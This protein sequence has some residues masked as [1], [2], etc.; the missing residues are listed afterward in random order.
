M[1]LCL[2][3]LVIDVLFA[4]GKGALP[5]TTC[6]R[7]FEK[8][9]CFVDNTRQGGAL[10]TLPDLLVNDRDPKSDAYDGHRLDWNKWPESIHSLACRCAN[11]TR[12]KGW[13]VFGLQFYGECWSGENGETTFNKYG[14]ANPKKCIQELVDPLP[15]CNKSKD[16]ECVGV[17]STNYI[18]KLKELK[19]Q[20]VNGGFSSWSQWT[21]CSK[22]CGGGTKSRER[23][24]TNP[25]PSGNGQ[26]CMG[27]AEEVEKCNEDQ[28]PD[29]CKRSLDVGLLID[30]ST[31]VGA[32]NFKKTLGFLS[33]L[34]GHLS[35]S[36]QGTHV[37]VMVFESQA[38]LHFNL[39]KSEYHSLSKLQSAIRALTYPGKGIRT[40]LALQMAAS[41]IFDSS[42]GDR[43]D[44][45]NLLVVLT[46]G[47]T[48]SGST[49]YKDVITLLQKKGVRTVA[50]GVG[51]KIDNKELLQIAAGN[52]KYVTHVNGFD[53]LRK[54][55]AKIVL[56]SCQGAGDVDGAW[57]DWMIWTQ[58]SKSC[59]GGVKARRRSCSN[60]PPNRNGQSC[61]GL[62]QET[63]ACSENPCPKPCTKALDVGIILDGSGSVR[64]SNFEKAKEF[65]RDLIEHFSVSPKGTHF[66]VIIYSTSPKLQLDFANAA[67]HRIVEL[68]KRVMSIKYPGGLTRTDKALEM[69]AQKLFTVAGGDRKDKPNVLLVFT[70]GKTNRGSKPYPVVLRPL[71]ARG[72]RTVAVGIGRGINQRELLQIAMSNNHYVV[73]VQNF[74]SLKGKLQMILDE[75]CQDA[76]PPSPNPECREGV[77]GMENRNIP[78]KAITASSQWDANHGPDRAR[79]NMVRSGHKRGA[80]SAKY[81]DIGQF[82]QVDI[83]KVVKI[84]KVLTQGRSDSDQWVKTYW[85]SYSLNGGYYQAYGE[86][87]PVTLTGNVDRNTVKV[88]ILDEPIY[89]RFIRVHP[90]TFHRHI[91]LRLELYGC[92]TGFVPPSPPLCMNALGMQSGKIRPADIQASSQYDHNHRPDNGRLHFQ[93]APPRT[94]AWSS[95]TNNLNQWFQVKFER[96]A[97]VRRVGCQGRMDADQWVKKY[98]LAYSFDGKNWK[99]YGFNGKV[100]EF[101]GN[102]DRYSV[103]TET[104]DPPIIARYVRVK[105]RAW[106]RHISLRLEF[107]GCTEDGDICNVK[108]PCKNGA[109]CINLVGGYSCK[110]PDG[111]KGKN[112]DQDI[113]ECLSSPCKNG[114]RCT[115]TAGGYTCKCIGGWFT[116]KNCD[117]APPECIVNTKLSEGNRASGNLR[118]NFLKCD[119]R[120]LATVGKW[121][122]FVGDAGT[123]IP[124][125]CVPTQR[126]GTHAPGWMQGEHP[127]KEDGVVNRK[128]CFHWSRNCCRWSVLIKVRNCSGYF[129][130][131]LEKPPVCYLRYCGDKGHNVCEP[132]NPCRNGG[133]CKPQGSGYYC[134]CRPGYQG[135]NCDKDINECAVN[136]PCRNGGTCINAVGRYR[137]R[138]S[139]KFTGR[140]CEKDVNECN[141]HKPCKNG[142]TCV[143]NVGGYSCRCPANYKGRH[144]DKDVNECLPI[145]PCKN[146]GVCKNTRG[147]YQCT[148]VGR[149]FTGKLCDQD[150]NECLPTN[151]CKNGGVCKNIKGSYQCTCNGRFYGGKNCD[152]APV[153]CSSYTTLNTADRASKPSNNIFKCDRNDLSAVPKWYRFS[154]AAGTKMPTSSV[155]INHCGTRAPGWMNGQH[156]S[157][158]DGPVS[159]KVCFHWS[160]NVCRWSIQITVRSCGSFFVYKLPRT[161]YCSLRYCG[162][163]GYN[164]CMVKNPCQN[165]GTCQPDGNGYKCKC[166]PGFTGN[167]CEQDVNECLPINPCKNGGVCKNTKGSYQCTCNGRFYGGKNCDQAPV[168]CSSYT[169]LNTADRAS[170]PSN[171]IFKCD[172]N[173]LSSVPKWYRFSGAAGTKMP[174]SSVPINHCGTRAPGWMNGQHPSKNDGPVS[175]KVCFHW[176]NNVCRWSIQ[177]TVRSC[178]SF[179]VY[180][181]P[182]TNYCSLR[183][184]GDNGYNKCMVKNP[185]QNSGTCQPDGNGYKCK[186]SPGFTGNNCE[187]DVNECLPINPCKNGGVCK[188]TKG[189][190]QCTCNGRFYGG[191]NCDQ[192]PV[193]C[194]S[195]TTL[196]TADR[197]SKP[198]NNIFKCDRNDLSAVPK[199]YRFSGAAGTKMPTSSV[200]INHCGTRAPG[201]MNGQHPSKNDGPVS[202]KVCFHWSNN[203][204]RWS[205]QI[206]VRSCGSFFVYKL[207]RTNYCSLRYCGDNGY[208][209]CMVKNPCQNS[210][211]CQPDGNGYKCKCSP[212]F[213]GNNCEQ[214]VNEC[215]PINPCKN[216]GVCKNT[217]G[218]YQC[219]CV[220]R[221]Y[222]GKNC[223]RAPVECSS[224]TT[225]NTADRASKPSNNIFKCDRNDL[226]SVPKW[227][228]FSGAAGTKM[229]TSSVPINHCGTRAPGWMNGQHPSKNDGPVSRKVCFHWS[230]NVCRWSIQITVRSCGSFFVYKLPRTNYCSLRYCGDNGHNVDECATVKPCKNGGQCRN[231]RGGYTCVCA[232]GFVGKNCEQIFVPPECK[233]Y[234]VISDKTRSKDFSGGRAYCDRDDLRTAG[235][236]H[237]FMGDAGTAMPTSCV[238]TQRCGT[239]APGWLQNGHPSVEQ[240][241]VTRKVCFHW[242]NNCCKWSVNIKIRNC[243]D[244]YVYQLPKTRL[245]HLRYCSEKQEPGV[246][247]SCKRPLDIGV[248]IDRSGSIGA[249]NFGKAKNFVIS[250][251]HKLPI[252]SHGT[253]LG[254]IPYNS[255]AQVS[256]RFSDVQHQTPDAMARLIRGIPY[257]SGNTRTDVAI[258]LANS[259]LF[260]SSGGDRTDKDNVLIVMTDGK[261]NHGSKP[262]KTVLAP[263][264][265][266]GV[267]LIAVGVGSRVDD[268]ELVEIA[269]GKRENVVHVDKFDELVG[270]ENNVLYASCEPDSPTPPCTQAMDVGV[271]MDRSGSVG[272]VNF[273]KSRTFVRT[274]V[275]RFQISSRGTRVGIIAYN[276]QAQCVVRF[277]DVNSQTP[278][279]MT[280]IINR[281]S[282]TGGGTRTD[283]ALQMANSGLF[284]S[285]GGD[286]G[287]KRNV[288][289]VITDGKTNRGSKPYSSVLAPLIAKKVKMIAVGVG[290]GIDYSEL[291]EIANNKPA[292]VIHVDK[293]EDLF[294][295]LNNVMRASCE[296]E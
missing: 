178:G 71:Q 248:I 272:S 286:R 132:K 204:C 36:P 225:L 134:R 287:D 2:F 184:C 49:P 86:S 195:Y 32:G 68:K 107:Y 104:I 258:E 124:N 155:P 64:S 15:P 231:T 81:N 218:S 280:S 151:P 176:S 127:K 192:A 115:N 166:S 26:G 83:G 186:C 293:F 228:R 264:K 82:I 233:S 136:N 220:G 44:A 241:A 76:P 101:R 150:V 247:A 294:V 215:L 252:S 140:N 237:R 130:Y 148:C 206:T 157:K 149:W 30:G 65:V 144:C 211:T 240:G 259:Q 208:N 141:L 117:E 80:W 256:V 34:V 207:P 139:A 88:N 221:F 189:S 223:D 40:D 57:S 217:K 105:P 295:R 52:P 3:F 198:S 122:Q 41:Q 194:S 67:Y 278:S 37:A 285:S 270:N 29:P 180:K 17:Q 290:S 182:R 110:C 109:Q 249:A 283:I 200:P 172:R 229:P 183:Y 289:V 214:D 168:E 209:K 73:Q 199:W 85:L 162:D 235:K 55:L 146:G 257:T 292:N 227:Y 59:G 74:D 156:P 268:A 284:S 6:E 250:L 97:N 265:V 242:S 99:D 273:K 245:C 188:N 61:V 100:T 152:Q 35:V 111:F 282:Y 193:E 274:L 147:S 53:D 9:G 179:F 154:G 277:A 91:S 175:R 27:D 201:W 102:N 92:K 244:F 120:N 121:H 116:G 167:N 216:G 103:V 13:K 11:A 143:N 12:G 48:S 160:N 87:S 226:S 253:R 135:K 24:C 203:V 133:T 72:V 14:D 153:E 190:Y 158:N 94:G 56:D 75:S 114:A 43:N 261:T 23:T 47:K 70:D 98:T 234:E 246:P 5:H 262:Y 119:R 181:L 185:C 159:R 46:S 10:R 66:G 128:V 112:C 232:S 254:I 42:G 129:V 118:R 113:N 126:C 51:N 173:D 279:A 137:C 96:V 288:L 38:T 236:W 22:S 269:D 79:L 39:A 31:N 106:H 25:P 275:H 77:L 260:S 230:N 4:I 169:T 255:R 196:N 281:I 271:I 197:A 131:K 78:D 16:M 165:S 263:L 238:P 1:R 170:K 54:N 108:K 123:K 89:T 95:R 266:K 138:C 125:S 291:R 210:G 161:N 171:N 21:E 222:G 224:Y 142:A 63:A 8:V 84:T 202:R 239:H 19:P 296:P 251:V 33:D 276:A 191:K 163:N 69:A 243:G 219:T 177:I 60:P 267:R 145:N 45:D 28:C 90:K 62:V 174:T 213:T 93:K 164:K 212:G 20:D 187:Q 50:I 18:Y 58:C 205:I 7:T